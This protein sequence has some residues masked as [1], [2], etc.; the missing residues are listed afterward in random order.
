MSTDTTGAQAP[1][2][3]F[4]PNQPAT[5]LFDGMTPPTPPPAA[6]PTPPRSTHRGGA[7]VAA[8]GYSIFRRLMVAL[9]VV[10]A[11]FVI[12]MLAFVFAGLH[13]ASSPYQAPAQTK[14]N[15]PAVQVPVKPPPAPSGPIGDKQAAPDKL[16]FAMEAQRMN[17]IKSGS[18]S[19]LQRDWLN[20]SANGYRYDLA[21]MGK[22]IDFNGFSNATHDGDTVNVEWAQMT[23]GGVAMNYTITYQW[24]PSQ[25]RWVTVSRTH[26]QKA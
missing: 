5:G 14:A 1:T 17:D 22:Q 12:T 16:T 24:S 13:H 23:V 8:A 26:E 15:A 9:M 6:A 25:N 21:L 10:A 3:P 4:V 20:T 18:E 11:F 19:Q 7:L 2:T